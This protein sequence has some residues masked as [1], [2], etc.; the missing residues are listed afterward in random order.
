MRT[1]LL[2]RTR[3]TFVSPEGNLSGGLWSVIQV[4]TDR[5]GAGIRRRGVDY[6]TCA[7]K[8]RRTSSSTAAPG[9]AQT[10]RLKISTSTGPR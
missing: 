10:W 2:V 6:R 9:R 8:L 5:D 7:A 1:R 4:P 3:T